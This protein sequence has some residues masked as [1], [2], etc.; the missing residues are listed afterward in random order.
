MAH[1]TLRQ[2]ILGQG[3]SACLQTA[4][5]RD[6]PAMK[7]RGISDD[8]SRGPVPTLEF[9]KHE[10]RMLAAYKMNIYSPYMEVSF[11]YANNPLPAPP[12]GAMTPADL[13]ALTQYAQQYHVTIV[14]QQE[15]FGHLHHALMFEK[16]SPLGGNAAGQRVRARTAGF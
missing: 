3:S 10:V 9:Q 6:W 13:R 15:A 5:V 14:P 2:L 12:G 16:Y 8:L 7:Y 4:T 1:R 11:A